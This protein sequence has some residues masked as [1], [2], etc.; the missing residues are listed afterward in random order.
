MPFTTVAA[1]TTILANAMKALDSL[2]EQAKG[3]KD[4][5][6]KESISNLYDNLLDMKAAV[7]RVEEENS[8]LRR[9][10]A[11][12]AEK[13]PN[14]EPRQVGKAIYYFVG[15]KGPYCQPCYDGNHKLALL[16]PQAEYAGGLGR[17]CEVCNKVFFETVGSPA[18]LQ[19]G[20]H[21]NPEEWMR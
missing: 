11:Q 8:E 4:A 12:Q 13:L 6:L 7:I 18:R 21:G 10:I 3:S 9:T 1:A 14:P 5:A 16:A 17:K 19:F 20:G 15:D 2:R